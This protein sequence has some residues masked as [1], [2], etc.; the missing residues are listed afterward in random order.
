MA[1]SATEVAA[2]YLPILLFLA[3]ALFISCAFV[4]APMLVQRF[5]GAYKPSPEKLTE[6]EC[7]FPAFEDSRSQYDVRFYLVAILFI[8]FDL[9]AAFLYPWAVS[10]YGTGIAGWSAMMIFL[11]E[12][13]LGYIYAWKVGAL[14]WE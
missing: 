6:Y 9:E 12:L 5:T 1:L 14:E 10:L 13:I 4:F 11:A 2:G 7:G 8:I 3:I